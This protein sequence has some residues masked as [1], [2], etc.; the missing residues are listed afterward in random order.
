MCECQWGGC[1]SM[2]SSKMLQRI[3]VRIWKG[4]VSILDSRPLLTQAITTG[5]VCGLGDVIAQSCVEGRRWKQ[6]SLQRT[7]KMAAIGL[8]FTGPVLR[9]WFLTLD[10]YLGPSTTSAVVLKKVFL[11]QV[12]F[13]PLLVGSLLS[14]FALSQS[15]SISHV[16][17]KLRGDYFNLLF[18]SYKLWPFVQVVNF[19]FIPLKFRVNFLNIISLF[20]NTYVAWLA[21]RPLPN[22]QDDKFNQTK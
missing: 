9:T 20:W 6:Y 4:Y 16:K 15:L 17:E 13:A 12:A 19:Y 2:H 14:L 11:D 18:A 1:V 8:C 5:V 7:A 22:Q 21:N 10:K 3:A